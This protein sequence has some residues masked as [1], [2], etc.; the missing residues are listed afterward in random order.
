[1]INFHPFVKNILEKKYYFRKFLKF[2]MFG[3]TI[4]NLLIIESFFHWIFWKPKIEY[5]I[6]TW[7]VLGIV[8]KLSPSL[9]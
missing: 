4:W 6:G 5:Y 9:I 2:R 3:A 7:E 1:M 8:R